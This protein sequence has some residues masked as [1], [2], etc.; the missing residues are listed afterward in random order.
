VADADPREGGEPA[1]A[2]YI[3][4]KED[5]NMNDNQHY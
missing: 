3:I 1:L 5:V 4:T 2:P